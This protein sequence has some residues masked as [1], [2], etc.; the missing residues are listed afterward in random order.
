MTPFLVGFTDELVKTAALG[1]VLKR[2]GKFTIKHPLV[3][4][5]A[6]GTIGATALAAKGGYQ[7]GLQGGERPRYLGAQVDRNSGQAAASE[8]AYTNFHDMLNQRPRRG[9]LKRLHRHYDESKFKR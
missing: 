7:Q 6:A 2:V 8:A 3:A 9:Q 5:T 4:L 1:G